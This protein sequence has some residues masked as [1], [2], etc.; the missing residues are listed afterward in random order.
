MAR[1]TTTANTPWRQ[2]A[3]TAMGGTAAAI[4]MAPAGTPRPIIDKLH[5]ELVKITSNPELRRQ[6]GAQG[7]AALTMGVDEFTKYLNDDITKWSNLVKSAGIK[8]D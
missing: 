2:P 3:A 4:S 1:K 7:S 8:V 6:W 5:G